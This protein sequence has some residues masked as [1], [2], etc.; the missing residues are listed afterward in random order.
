MT[1]TVR[2]KTA[3]PGVEEPAQLKVTPKI[4][5]PHREF[6]FDLTHS[7]GPG[8]QG[9]N[10]VNTKAVMHWDMARSP[11][12]KPDVKERFHAKYHKRIRQDGVV[13]LMSQRTRDA[14]SNQKDCLDKLKKMLLA[15]ATAPTPRKKT[16]PRRAAREQRLE[17][18]HKVSAKKQNRAKVR[19]D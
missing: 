5:I 1:S 18:K 8:G 9:V 7:S 17:K 19:M 13:V 14:H 3:T 15:V 4:R 11:S 2:P 6:H 16:K 12:L 10:K